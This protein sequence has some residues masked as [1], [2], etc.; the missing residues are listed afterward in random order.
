MAITY[1][2]QTSYKLRSPSGS[3]RTATSA[4]GRKF[5][6]YD[7]NRPLAQQTPY[8]PLIAEVLVEIDTCEAQIADAKT[9]HAVAAEAVNTYDEQS[10]TLV[11]YMI[12][13]LDANYP[14]NPSK[15]TEWG[16]T[17]KQATK[18]IIT[19]TTRDERLQVMKSYIAKEESR[20]EAER[21]NSPNL[22]EVIAVRQGLADNIKARDEGQNDREAAIAACK[23]KAEL[24]ANHLQA[25]A[26]NILSLQYN[27][28]LSPA[29]Q[30][31]GYD[32]VRKRS[33]SNGSNGTAE[34]EEATTDDSSPDTS[35][36]PATDSDSGQVNVSLL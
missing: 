32:V 31:W 20:P 5:V 9:R 35:P 23:T 30:N 21:F 34:P 16:F 8:T 7:Q 11:S 17:V 14:A 6:A 25:A 18:N 12:K 24:L 27:Y 36:E 4:C 26:V 13:T 22:A 19:P 29:L 10:K 1:R 2:D 33:D 3:N 15:A 28:E